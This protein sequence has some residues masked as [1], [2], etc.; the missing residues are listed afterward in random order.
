MNCNDTLGGKRSNRLSYVVDDAIDH[1]GYDDI[2]PGQVAGNYTYNKIGELT[3]D[4]SEGVLLDWRLGD[5]KLSRIKRT[6]ADSPELEFYYNPFGQRILKV[7]KPRQGGNVINPSQWKY[8]Y[9]SYDVNGQVMGVYT[10][11]PDQRNYQL[12]ERHLYGAERL[13]INGTPVK[14]IVDGNL[15]PFAHK[16]VDVVHTDQRGNK[17]YEL[18]N[19]LGNVLAVINDR[20]MWNVTDGNYDPVLLSWSDYYAFGMTMP[21]RNGNTE[22]YRYGYQGS[23]MDN[24]V[25]GNGNSYTTFFRQL[26]PRLGR[27]KSIDPVVHAHQSPYVSMDNNPIVHSD[28]LGDKRRV[29][30]KA[31][32]NKKFRE[33]HRARKDSPDMYVYR[34]R[35]GEPT[36]DNPNVVQDFKTAEIIDPRG[37]Q[38]RASMKTHNSVLYDKAGLGGGGFG[39]GGGSIGGSL[40][41]GFSLY[42][43]I[44]E[45]VVYKRGYKKR[46]FKRTEGFRTLSFKVKRSAEIHVKTF[47]RPDQVR[48]FDSDGNLVDHTDQNIHDSNPHHAFKRFHDEEDNYEY[49][50]TGQDVV[51][52]RVD[53]KGIYQIVVNQSGNAVSD[54]PEKHSPLTDYSIYIEGQNMRIRRRTVWRIREPSQ[55][56]IRRIKYRRDR[57][58]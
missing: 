14:V 31:L 57:K 10:A 56:I 18:T 43:Q 36:L 49:I 40:D 41:G 12:D 54:D 23:E 2:K 6:D 19:H 47:N 39:S 33:E 35:D 4:A 25:K 44:I 50:A 13:G 30:F 16:R 46:D 37:G 26:D 38:T 24:E 27:W 1:P 11:N 22:E 7:E 3:E 42:K 48:I 5:H 51:I 52:L 34:R 17:R 20:K 21:G 55:A 32:F 29:A 45:T 28:P 8:T 9:Y 58:K 53:D 15:E